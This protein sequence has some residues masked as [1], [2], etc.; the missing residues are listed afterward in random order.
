MRKGGG[1]KG[2]GTERGREAGFTL[3]TWGGGERERESGEYKHNVASFEVG[4]EYRH[5]FQAV[6][7]E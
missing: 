6:A 2:E 1:S 5:I 7:L 4:R 3:R